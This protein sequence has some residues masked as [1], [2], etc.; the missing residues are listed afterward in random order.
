[1]PS[2]RAMPALR[3]TAIDMPMTERLLGSGAEHAQRK[4][5]KSQTYFRQMLHPPPLL[6]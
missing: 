3:L 4:G 5:T 6:L 1:M 2:A